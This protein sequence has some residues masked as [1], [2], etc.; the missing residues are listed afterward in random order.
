MSTIFCI[1]NFA[2]IE[3]SISFNT[4]PSHSMINNFILSSYEYAKDL[5]GYIKNAQ[6]H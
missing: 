3:T 4:V 5:S 1:F 6:C 2:I